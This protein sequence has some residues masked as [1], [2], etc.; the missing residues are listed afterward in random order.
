MGKDKNENSESK[1]P[2][3]KLDVYIRSAKERSGFPKEVPL[4]AKFDKKNWEMLWYRGFETP[5]LRKV[6]VF[7]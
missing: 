1:L 6:A 5:S 4:L 7:H 2:K 3:P